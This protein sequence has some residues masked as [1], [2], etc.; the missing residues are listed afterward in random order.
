MA[1]L[2]TN[3]LLK[4]NLSRKTGLHR[5]TDEETE[6]IKNVVLEAALDVI[7][8]CDENG[9]PYMLGGGSALGAVRHGGFIP[10]DDDIDLNIPRKYIT[11]LIHAIE[12]RYP[13]KYYIEAPLYTEGYLSSFIQVHRKNT[14]FQEYMHQNKKNCGIKLDIFIIENTYN[15][16]KNEK[17][18]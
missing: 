12:N 10:W 13:D 15:N 1:V 14:V 17:I 7:A 2:Q 5:L 9:I 18:Q 6:A 11:Q 16:R 8:L 3:E 4:E